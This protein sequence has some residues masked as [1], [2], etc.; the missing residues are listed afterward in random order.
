LQSADGKL[1]S[2]NGSNL[3]Q[4]SSQKLTFSFS[5][6][7]KQPTNSFQ[8]AK[9]AKTGDKR[10]VPLFDDKPEKK[11]KTDE[12]EYITG[13]D[14]SGIQRYDLIVL[15]IFDTGSDDAG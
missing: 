15:A 10:P 3:P 7:K 13:V 4:M 14:E 2:S 8:K 1:S 11:P 5:G 9:P 6:K 12:I